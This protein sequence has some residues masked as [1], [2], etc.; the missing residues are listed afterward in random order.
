MANNPQI[1]TTALKKIVE[2]L[3]QGKISKEEA[4]AKVMAAFN[5]PPTRP[6]CGDFGTRQDGSNCP[7][8][9]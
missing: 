4:E 8:H 1:D 5:L 6:E 2:E 7:C 9:Y 3:E